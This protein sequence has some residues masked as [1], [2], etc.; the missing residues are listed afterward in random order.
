MTS[1]SITKLYDSFATRL[2]KEPAE[3][4]TSFI[5]E[6]IKMDIDNNMKMLATRESVARVKSDLIKWM[7]VFWV[8]QIAA[9]VTFI[10]LFVKK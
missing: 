6:K 1:T 10:L 7:F 8:G 9:T 3:N 4:L 5:E 2:G